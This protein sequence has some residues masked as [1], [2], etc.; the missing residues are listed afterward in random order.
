MKNIKNKSEFLN[1][2]IVITGASS[3]IGLS[4][5]IYFL[6][7]G[8]QVIMAGRDIDTMNNICQ[9][10]NFINATVMKLD[11]KDDIQ[12]ID[13][14]SS[15]V[16]RFKKI[17]LLINCAGVTLYGDVEK[18]YPQDFDVILDIN[19]RSLYFLI[20]QLAGFMHK[21]SSIIN[22]SCLY[23]SKPMSGMISYS[24][25]KAG[26]EGLTRYCAAEF[27]KFNI[28]VNC[29]SACPV[30]TNWFEYIEIPENEK[31]DFVNKMEKYIP[32]GR[33]AN[34][35]D[36]VKV[37]AFLASEKSKNITG[38]IIK[39]DGGRS[40]TSSGY[41]HYKGRLNMNSRIEPDGEKTFYKITNFIENKI[42]GNEIPKDEKDL[43]RYI[44]DKMEES[45]FSKNAQS[46]Y[47]INY[48]SVNKYISPQKINDINLKLYSDFKSEPKILTTKKE[49]E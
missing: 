41:V 48:T 7:L 45:C 14:K 10:Y 34:P 42:F 19:I 25:S 39:V 26:V 13:F 3:G 5:S 36:I 43:E 38:Q 22:M 49:D 2:K 17:D 46:S 4:A 28:R 11:L 20:N 44:E 1:K 27:A 32:L 30:Y 47:E 33:I 35:V 8:A 6:N 9:K 24:I 21:N 31:K 29:I 37:I 18:T 40:L 12:I 23:G 15:V 16:E